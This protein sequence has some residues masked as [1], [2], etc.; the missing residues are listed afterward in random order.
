MSENRQVKRD[1]EKSSMVNEV[2][3]TI[4]SQSFFFF[5]KRFCAHKKYQNAKQTTFTL[6]EILCAQKIVAFVI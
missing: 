6:L 4:L 5:A 3:R 2:I 1:N